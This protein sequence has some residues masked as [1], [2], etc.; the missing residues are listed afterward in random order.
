MRIA[1]ELYHKVRMTCYFVYPLFYYAIS[2]L[3]PKYLWF[4][5]SRLDSEQENKPLTHNYI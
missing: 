2:A 4:I 5:C 3:E 1:P